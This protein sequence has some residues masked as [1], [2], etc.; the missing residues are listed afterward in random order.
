VRVALDTNIM[1][2]AEGVDGEAMQ[3]RVLEVTLVLDPAQM[4]VAVQALGE[5]FNVLVRKG[6]RTRDEASLRVQQWRSSLNVIDTSS[7]LLIAAI[8]LSAAH[9]LFI[10]D[11][12]ILA[13]AAQAGCRVLLSEDMHDGFTWHRT[14][15]VN[16]FATTP[17]PL[18]SQLRD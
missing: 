17:H 7:E 10:W 15:V 8:E 5:L 18:L 3:Q 16:P 4:V 6:G 13:S 11:A 1:A 12:V 2:Y 14:T 9:K